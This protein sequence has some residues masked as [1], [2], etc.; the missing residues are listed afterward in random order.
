MF[1]AA[2]GAEGYALQH[3]PSLLQSCGNDLRL[4]PSMSWIPTCYTLLTLMLPLQSGKTA[5]ACHWLKLHIIPLW[6]IVPLAQPRAACCGLK[7]NVEL[8]YATV[9]P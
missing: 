1:H 3:Y 5:T 9:G 7:H 4:C 2:V 6:I 8:D